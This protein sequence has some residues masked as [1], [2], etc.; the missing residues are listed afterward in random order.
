MEKLNLTF[1]E[2][3]PLLNLRGEEYVI[4]F[5]RSEADE[6]VCNDNW[7]HYNNG[8]CYMIDQDC[9][10]FELDMDVDNLKVLKIGVSSTC[11]CAIYVLDNNGYLNVIED[12]L[13]E[14]YED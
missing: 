3:K 1:G 7:V 9:E 13:C 12:M 10:E 5:L 6:Y 4:V 8:I 11:E 14:L 2:L